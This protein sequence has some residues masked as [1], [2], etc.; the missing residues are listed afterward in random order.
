M[1]DITLKTAIRKESGK[2]S[3]HKLRAMGLIPAVL[4]GHKEDPVALELQEHEF[5]HILHNSTTE[6][7]ILKLDIEGADGGEHV[8]LVRDVQH[9]PVTGNILHVDFQK[10]SLDEDIKVGVPVELVGHA[11][12][13]KDFGGILDHGVREVMIQ[14]K[15]AEIPEILEIDVSSMNIGD[16]LHVDYLVEKYPSLNFLDDL[17]VTLAH[18]SPP[19][20][21]ELL[22]AEE[23]AEVGAAEEGEEEAAEEAPEDK[24]EQ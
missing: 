21:A 10:I 11:V 16:T 4:Y 20:K 19:K 17:K 18:V 6:H 3:A 2:K 24:E 23:E 5:W 9:H 13:V 22:E 8:I 14:C 7:I 12:G 1:L 15:P